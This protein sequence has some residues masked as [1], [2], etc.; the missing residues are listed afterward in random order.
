MR[1]IDKT[2]SLLDGGYGKQ[3]K[4]H[5]PFALN[6][7]HFDYS[8]TLFGQQS[9]IEYSYLLKGF[10]KAW[11]KWSAKPEKDYI[12]LP[13][14]DY[15]FMVKARNN[16]GNES[17]PAAYSFA[18]LSPWY[19]SGFAYSIYSV[20]IFGFFIFGYCLQKKKFLLQKERFEKQ[21]KQTEYLYQLELEKNEK[22]IVKLRTFIYVF[23]IIMFG[24][25]IAFYSYLNATKLIGG[26]KTS[27]LVSVEPLVAVL[28][29]VIWLKTPFMLYDWAGTACIVSTVFLLTRKS[30]SDKQ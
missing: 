4:V 12:N 29:G 1:T 25:L 3:E 17:E 5:L 18:V 11:S 8:A 10:D 7:I 26:K 13:A 15:V 16:L 22:E 21:Q 30:N 27:L 20:F 2:D 14:G 28:L 24:T 19:R 23:F 9:N 6:S